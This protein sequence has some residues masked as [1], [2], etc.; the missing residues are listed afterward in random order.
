MEQIDNALGGWQV[1]AVVAGAGLAWTSAA[2]VATEPGCVLLSTRRRESRAPTT[3]QP[4]R[5]SSSS[6]RSWPA[7]SPAPC[8]Y[9]SPRRDRRLADIAT[10]PRTPGRRQPS[11]V[12]ADVV[13]SGDHELAED[14]VGLRIAQVAGAPAGARGISLVA[15]RPGNSSSGTTE[16]SAN[17]TMWCWPASTTR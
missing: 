15:H 4:R 10:A 6:S 5:W 11:P 9:Q 17:A 3:G 1:P 7:G 8:V 13:A 14:V 16:V 2:N 12:R